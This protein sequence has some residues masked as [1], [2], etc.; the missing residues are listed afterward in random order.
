[1]RSAFLAPASLSGFAGLLGALFGRLL[2]AGG[3]CL[4]GIRGAGGGFFRAGAFAERD[5]G[6]ILLGH[7]DR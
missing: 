2:H 6:G 5:G 1:M 4:C 3:C 7:I